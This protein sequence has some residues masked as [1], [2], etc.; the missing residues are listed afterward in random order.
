M[1]KPEVATMAPA[2]K[3]IAIVKIFFFIFSTP[4]KNRNFVFQGPVRFDLTDL[5]I[6]IIRAIFEMSI[7]KW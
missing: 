3:L 1:Q 5:S 6:M 4:F 2:K 7:N